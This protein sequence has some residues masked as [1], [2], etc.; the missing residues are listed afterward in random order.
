MKIITEVPNFTLK[1]PFEKY[2]RYI[3]A[4]IPSKDLTGLTEVRFIEKFSNFKTSDNALGRYLQG[5]NG[6]NAAIEVNISNLIKSEAPEHLFENYFE[7]AALVLSWIISHEIGHHAHTFKRHGVKKKD[8]EQ[9][10]DRYSE[11]GYFEYLKSR[12][13]K[14]LS[15]YRWASF[16]FFRFDKKGR[17]SFSDNRQE[18]I[19]MLNKKDKP[20]F[21]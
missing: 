3:F 19:E 8:I 5:N 2:C 21:P 7:I 16:N 12:S 15:T 20:V 18:L 1:F 6:K 9:F 17:R 14:I 13:S 4:V 10:A 11:A